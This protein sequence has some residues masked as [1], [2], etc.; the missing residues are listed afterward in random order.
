M[1]TSAEDQ[2]TAW[3]ALRRDAVR[4]FAAFFAVFVLWALTMPLF[5][6]PD[7][8]WHMV[9]AQGYANLDLTNPF[10]TDGLPVDAGSCYQFFPEVSAEC[11]TL[12]WGP[13]G[14]EVVSRATDY[15]PASHLIAAL[16]AT[17]FSGAAGAYAMRVWMAVVVAG[18]FSW[19]GALYLRSVPSRRDGVLALAL[20]TT[21]MVAFMSGAVSPS[22]LTAA[23]T[24]L[25]VAATLH[26]RA[27]GSQ[28][29]NIVALIA[30][31]VLV[32]GS[33]RDGIVWASV[34]MISL[35]P[36]G[37]GPLRASWGRQSAKRRATALIG[38][39][40]FGALAGPRLVEYG[41]NFIRRHSIEVAG[42][43]QEARASFRDLGYVRDIIGRFGWLDTRLPNAVYWVAIATVLIW[44]VSRWIDA[45]GRERWAAG[46]A[47]VAL[48]CAPLIIG[49]FRS[50]YIQGR[51]L[52]PVWCAAMLALG[53]SVNTRRAGSWRRHFHAPIGLLWGIVHITAWYVTLRRHAVGID[54][55]WA[56]WAWDHWS[57][58]VIGTAGAL[59]L[60]VISIVIVAWVVHTLCR[61]VRGAARNQRTSLT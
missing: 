23:A 43:R 27:V 42:L 17:V 36:L 24:C 51:Y 1:S 41:L 34:M 50:P 3:S 37:W 53:S 35:A 12:D 56:A 25:C 32:V 9:N 55:P 21:P 22:G 20:A 44:V 48:F 38:L 30:G 46:V 60:Y 58:P 39:V 26:A 5:A 52:F 54:G 28:R 10:V 61:D 13:P 19:A 8:Q 4:L 59:V 49:L 57:P 7:E 11:M 6:A 15:P 2:P 18:V 40:A 31:L 14:T 33:R 47:V 16:P 29:L 45:S